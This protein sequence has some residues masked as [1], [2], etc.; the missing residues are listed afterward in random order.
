MK[1][2]AVTTGRESVNHTL[3]QHLHDAA[4][5]VQLAYSELTTP[6]RRVLEDLLLAHVFYLNRIAP[7]RKL[8]KAD[9]HLRGLPYLEL[10]GKT[11]EKMASAWYDLAADMSLMEF[12]EAFCRGYVLEMVKHLICLK[13][14][15]GHEPG[16][17]ACATDYGRRTYYRPANVN[18]AGL[19][20]YR[21]YAE[22][23]TPE[24][25]VLEDVLLKH[26]SLPDGPNAYGE[27]GAWNLIERRWAYF[28]LKDKISPP[29]TTAWLNWSW[30]TSMGRLGPD[31]CRGLI[32]TML[33]DLVAL[34]FMESPLPGSDTGS[35]AKK[36][37][38]LRPQVNGRKRAPVRPLGGEG[39]P[40]CT[41]AAAIK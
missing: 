5:K 16:A 1:T 39:E 36:A 33:H 25:R 34:R 13:F 2:T 28:Q 7:Y 12:P 15:G 14:R 37:R 32:L 40:S 31:P 19:E 6:Q 4:A 20:V 17:G 29:M 3:P 21:I 26:A 38:S 11:T 18:G 10:L 30:E 24:R 8:K 23:R 9:E 22:L 35:T 41:L 27:W